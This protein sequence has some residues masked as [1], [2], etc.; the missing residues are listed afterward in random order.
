MNAQHW[1]WGFGQQQQTKPIDV[2][3]TARFVWCV[4]NCARIL[5]GQDPEP[6]PQP[7]P[8]PTPAPQVEFAK[9]PE[10]AAKLLGVSVDASTDAIRAALRARMGNG[11]H[12]DHGGDERVA[13]Q[14]I[15]AK[16]L[17]VEHARRKS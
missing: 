8:T 16:N 7:P 11:A 2:E 6:W 14:L 9:T 15:A 4:V 1:W 13:Q 12:P 10:A 5:N 17:L 3:G